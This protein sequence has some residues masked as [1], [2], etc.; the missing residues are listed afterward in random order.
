M[1]LPSDPSHQNHESSNSGHSI[2][3]PTPD[4][5]DRYAKYLANWGGLIK[6]V[7]EAPNIPSKWKFMFFLSLPYVAATTT[8]AVA[9][10][11]LYA[12]AFPLIPFLV[13]MLFLLYHRFET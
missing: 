7:A 9:R 13:V 8:M 11:P 6:A 3:E 5:P 10:A 2:C 1:K 12:F 4:A